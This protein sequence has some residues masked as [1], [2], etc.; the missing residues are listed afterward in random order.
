MAARRQRRPWKDVQ[1]SC[2]GQQQPKTH[3]FSTSQIFDLIC[4]LQKSRPNFYPV[5]WAEFFGKWKN[6][7]LTLE[8]V[9]GWQILFPLRFANSHFYFFRA[10]EFGRFQSVCPFKE[11]CKLIRKIFVRRP[12]AN[13]RDDRVTLKSRALS[14]CHCW[15][16]LLSSIKW[17]SKVSMTRSLVEEES[18][19]K[20][21]SLSFRPFNA[22]PQPGV[23][24]PLS[25]LSPHK[26]EANRDVEGKLFLC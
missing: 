6:L 16:N 17:R 14:F 26:E 25:P 12:S 13:A 19:R 5:A 15:D 22:N 11:L 8:E 1:K 20:V 18:W 9:L 7:S 4:S 24:I 3:F 21:T 10:F 2:F 23:N